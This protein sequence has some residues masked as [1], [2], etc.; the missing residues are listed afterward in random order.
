MYDKIM[1]FSLELIGKFTTN[2]KVIPY[3]LERRKMGTGRGKLNRV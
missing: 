3:G 1:K 2:V